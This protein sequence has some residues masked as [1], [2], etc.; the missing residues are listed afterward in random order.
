MKPLPELPVP[1]GLVRVLVTGSRDW[2][3]QGAVT[4]AL[5]FYLRYSDTLTVVHGGAARGADRMAHDW[6]AGQDITRDMTVQEEK[7]PA[8][9]DYYGRRAGMVRNEVMVTAGAFVCLAFIMPC[10]SPKCRKAKPHGSHGATNC[11][12]L[13]EESG[14]TTVRWT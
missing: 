11:A 12:D 6:C 3:D 2:W 8:L 13:A 1:V 4:H 14:I 9:W 5:D 10:S 7:H